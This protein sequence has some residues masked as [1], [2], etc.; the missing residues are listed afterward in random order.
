MRTIL[1]TGCSSGIGYAAAKTLSQRGWRVFATCRRD[2][3]CR[4]LT[5]EGLWSCRLDYEDPPSIA[6]AW[7]R[8]SEE[9]GGGLD[10]LF[11]NGAYAI[12]C[13]LEDLPSDGL[14]AIFEA[15]VFGWHELTRLVVPAMRDQGHGRIV[16]NSSILGFVAL[17]YRGAYNATK[18]AIEGL[19]DTLR[20]ELHGS[21]IE[22]VLIEPGP[23]GTKFRHNCYPPFQRWIDWQN[24]RH[25]AFY[26][27][28]LIPRLEAESLPTRFE[29]PADAVVQKLIH[30]LE[31]KRPKPRYYVTAPTHVMGVLR[32]LLP[33]RQLDAVSRAASS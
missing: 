3:D 18:F 22:V 6:E 19:S 30:A 29:L 13:L 1:I 31:A 12:P 9:T 5:D 27:E 7:E 32:R 10:A 11:N 17:M 24:S 2:E 4:R 21:G 14:R 25:R 15:N 28:K 33:T 8:V 23:I 26:A 20:L 16:Q